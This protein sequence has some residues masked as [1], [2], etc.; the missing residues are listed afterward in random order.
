MELSDT[1]LKNIITEAVSAG[2]TAGLGNGRKSF[3]Y[4]APG[5]T[6]T[7]NLIHGPGGIFGIPG[8]DN[9]VISARV[10]PRG[11]A[12]Y[13]PV[14]GS[15]YTNP[16]F[17]YITGVEEDAGLEP[18]TECETCLSGEIEGCI[19]TAQFGRVC[20]ETKTLA[21]NE[22]INRVNSGEVDLTLIND[23][24]GFGDDPMRAIQNAD[25]ST[26]M[27]VATVTAMMVVGIL[28]QNK[29]VQWWWQGNPANNI[30]TGYAEPPG[31]DIL[32]GTGKVDAL[33]GT[34]CP[35]LD[36]DVKEFNYQ[37]IATVDAGNNFVI[38]HL[39]EYLEAYLYHNATRM[40]LWPTQWAV[41][42]RPECWYEL[43]NVWPIAY[44][45]TRGLALPASNT[46]VINSGD[47]MRLRD[48]M[49]EGMFMFINGRRHPVILDDGIFEYNS[50]NDANL[51]AGQFASNIYMV[52]LTYL[53]N[54]PATF[55]Q[56]KDYRAA[57]P[58]LRA[59][60]LTDEIWTDNGRFLWTKE[61]EKWCYTLSG[62]VEPR[63]LLKTPQLAGRI[64]HVAYTPAQ[65]FRSF[66]QD[67]DYFEKG[68]VSYRTPSTYYSPWDGQ[69]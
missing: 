62:K 66:D 31:L 40:G 65:H 48:E 27:N 1:Q 25:G 47:V 17:P 52:P 51:A 20:R 43:T 9:Q 57:A 54:R 38:V 11:I 12:A 19:E 29:L 39:M 32:I 46:N 30:G 45:T 15:V 67:S 37:D 56:Y 64:N 58:D 68:G 4:K 35:A 26:L 18:D 23:I 69:R 41:A 50:T 49:M 60:R 42:M 10:S 3:G 22:I 59:A 6:V 24:M 8:L 5:T 53:G 14:F 16:L 36:S 33:T 34:T 13:L 2:V 21:P 63:I 28:L 55:I 44:V 7:T 61:R